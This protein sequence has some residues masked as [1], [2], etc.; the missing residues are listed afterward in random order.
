MT[1]WSAFGLDSMLCDPLRRR[2][3]VDK[4]ATVQTRAITRTAQRTRIRQARRANKLSIRTSSETLG[5]CFPFVPNKYFVVHVH[6]F[7]RPA[8]C[9]P[10]SIALA[11]VL[12]ADVCGVQTTYFRSSASV[13]VCGHLEN[14]R[15][16][17]KNGTRV[18]TRAS[19]VKKRRTKA[20]TKSSV[21]PCHGAIAVCA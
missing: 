7:I 6:M 11:A 16:V 12:V 4:N 13:F 15:V 18:S 8:T 3:A 10:N 19:F 9:V 20:H 21:F 5:S 17:R 14:M 2:E 1:L